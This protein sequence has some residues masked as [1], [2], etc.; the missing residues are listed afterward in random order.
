MTSAKSAVQAAHAAQLVVKDWVSMHPD[1]AILWLEQG[2]DL[3]VFTP[4]EKRFDEVVE[5]SAPEGVF[6]LS[7][8]VHDAGFTEVEAG[9]LTAVGVIAR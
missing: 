3:D 9:S 2:A 1:E 6:Y 7:H 8:Q 4:S 5:D